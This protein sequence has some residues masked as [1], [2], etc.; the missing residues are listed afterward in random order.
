MITLQRE[1]ERMAESLPSEFVLNLGSQASDYVAALAKALE[2]MGA[3]V[4]LREDGVLIA[5][6][7]NA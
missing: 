2:K 3:Q 5:T 7:P 1:A 6:R 4:E